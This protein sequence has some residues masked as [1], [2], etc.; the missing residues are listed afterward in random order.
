MIKSVGRLLRAGTR[1]IAQ[2]IKS[3]EGH[4]PPLSTE[5]VFG[6]YSG[7]LFSSASQAQ[8]LDVALADI[9]RLGELLRSREVREFIENISYTRLEQ[10]SVLDALAPELDPLVVSFLETLIDNRKLSLLP[11]IIAEFGEYFK[12]LNKEEA[13]KVISAQPLSIAQRQAMENTLRQKLSNGTFTVEYELNPALLGGFHIYFGN[14]FLDCSLATR[15]T[16]LRN[17]FQRLSV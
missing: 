5:S 10:R 9:Q 8:K 17:E 12:A 3:V 15:I 6:R 7:V 11:K 13:V 2:A 16:V 14:R 1:G 4:K